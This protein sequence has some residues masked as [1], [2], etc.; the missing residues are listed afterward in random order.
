MY[1]NRDL[2]ILVDLAG[3]WRM[4][5]GWQIIIR[6]EWVDQSPGRPHGLSYALILQNE[7]EKRLLG[8]DNS[9]LADDAAESDLWDHEHRT[10]AVGRTFAYKFKSVSQL[11]K[12]FFERCGSYCK[13][14]GVKFDVCDVEISS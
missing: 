3:T 14:Q 6:A 5:N 1:T 11:L 2:R 9:H 10:D 8:F 13:S 12:D 7:D 4:E